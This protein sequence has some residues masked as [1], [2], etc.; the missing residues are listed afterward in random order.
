MNDLKIGTKKCNFCGEDIDEGLRRCPYCG[1]LA[2]SKPYQGSGPAVD[3]A[4]YEGSGQNSRI[5]STFVVSPEGEVYK[6]EA[7]DRG[8]SSD[9]HADE[10]S[11]DV[12][13]IGS[14]YTK[15]AVD[16][17]HRTET[18]LRKE[19]LSN[20]FK[21]FLTAFCTAI[22]GLGQLIGI[23]AAIMFMNSDNEDKSSFGTALL[24]ASLVVFF[25]S[26]ITWFIIALALYK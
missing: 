5:A 20:G 15:E 7:A 18:N 23:I 19:A 8:C 14:F 11:K 4:K 22:P 3:Q 16:P 10:N 1:S 13:N 24:T 26:C 2:K 9:I 25:I 6:S 21:V 17:I 12:K